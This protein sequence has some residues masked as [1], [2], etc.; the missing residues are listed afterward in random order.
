MIFSVL[1]MTGSAF[2]EVVTS[3]Q[4][5]REQ[6]VHQA[7]DIGRDGGRRQEHVAR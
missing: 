2:L 5:K 6:L 4:A 7:D 3:A 1:N